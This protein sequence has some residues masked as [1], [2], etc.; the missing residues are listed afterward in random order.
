MS[1]SLLEKNGHDVAVSSDTET[2]S[3]KQKNQ[4]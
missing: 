1:D 3:Y 4:S 2:A